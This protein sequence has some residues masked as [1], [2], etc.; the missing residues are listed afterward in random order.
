MFDDKK[1]WKE[2]ASGRIKDLG[3]YLRYIFNGHLVVVLLFLLGTASFYYQNWIENLPA[4]FP[5][6]I[7]IAVIIGFLLTYSPVYNFLLDADQIFILP[8]EDKLKGYF[9]RSGIASL[10]FQGYLLLMVL[11]V[12]MPMYAHISGNGFRSFLPFF[13]I[14]LLVKAWNLAASW[15]IDFFVQSVVHRWDL[16]VR[17][18][19]NATFTF[20]LFK[21]ANLFILLVI[22]VVCALYYRTFSV[23]SNK[24]GLKWDL[25]INQEEKRMASF[26]RLANMF[27]DVP[28]LRDTVKRRKWLD[29]FLNRIAFSRENTYLYLFSR[30]FL[31]SSDY[32]GLFTRLTVIGAF[33]IYF[34]SFGIGQILLGILFLYLTGFQLLPLWNHHQN[35]LWVDLYPI[36]KRY[37]TAAF[38]SLLMTILAIQTVIYALLIL[39]KGELMI[40]LLFLLA[41]LVFTYLFVYIYAKNRLKA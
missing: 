33:A 24:M 17:Y 25:L 15:R 16:V 34:I 31:R 12:L 19:I 41:G 18:C 21:Q 35:K 11:A 32:L 23:Q 1:L 30:A 20:L 6:E 8:L 39:V 4:G 2:R 40:A 38:S 37:K 28:K 10:V 26:Y 27:T 3:K 22:V 5:V 36:E 13:I 29:L 7:V 14:L 9:L